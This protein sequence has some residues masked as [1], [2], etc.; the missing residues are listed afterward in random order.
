MMHYEPD[1]WY[2]VH[3]SISME[4]VSKALDRCQSWWDQYK[5][6]FSFLDNYQSLRELSRTKAIQGLLKLVVA[7]VRP[8]FFK[9]FDGNVFQI[10]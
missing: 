5:I 8:S 1:G 4:P 7:N 2:L 10:R 6:M 3:T 9:I